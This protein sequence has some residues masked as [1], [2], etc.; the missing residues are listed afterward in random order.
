V[1]RRGLAGGEE[2]REAWALEHTSYK[3]QKNQNFE[4]KNISLRKK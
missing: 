2:G 4:E 1:G 3:F